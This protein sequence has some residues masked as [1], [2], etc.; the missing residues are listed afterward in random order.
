M[1]DLWITTAER[2]TRGKLNHRLHY[3]LST[4]PATPFIVS[5]LRSPEKL[6]SRCLQDLRGFLSFPAHC[7]FL[8]TTFDLRT[9][10][11]PG[12]RRSGTLAS[13]VI[14]VTIPKRPDI[15]KSQAEKAGARSRAPR[16]APGRRW[17]SRVLAR[18]RLTSCPPADW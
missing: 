9:L 17:A 1:F 3:I 12:H 2:N 8:R 15:A 10:G 4:P 18:V 6:W 14:C 7:V 11:L 13:A 5:C 16:T